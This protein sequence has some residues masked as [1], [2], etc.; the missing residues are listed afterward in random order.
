MQTDRIRYETQCKNVRA[1]H[2]GESPELADVDLLIV[3]LTAMRKLPMH[4]QGRESRG[5]ILV[6][7]KVARPS[8]AI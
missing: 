1:I 7:F 3:I 8:S 5:P 6:L 4:E 2:P